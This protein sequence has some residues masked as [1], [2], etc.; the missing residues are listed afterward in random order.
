MVI[1]MLSMAGKQNAT[2]NVSVLA[3]PFPRTE[4]KFGNTDTS[5]TVGGIT[6]TRIETG[7]FNATYPSRWAFTGIEGIDTT[8]FNNGGGVLAS[9]VASSLG[10][11]FGVDVTVGMY[12]VSLPALSYGPESP[13]DWKFQGSNDNTTWTDLDTHTNIVTSDNA[14]INRVI[15]SPQSFR[16]YR[17]NVASTNGP[18]RWFIDGLWFYAPTTL[19]FSTTTADLGGH[20]LSGGNTIASKA[21]FGFDEAW[22]SSSFAKTSG[23]WWVR[24]QR[25][26]TTAPDNSSHYA[27]IGVGNANATP[28][29]FL[30]STG[31]WLNSGGSSDGVSGI[32]AWTG[33]GDVIDMVYDISGN[34][35]AVR[36]NN[37]TWGSDKA[38]TFSGSILPFVICRP[39]SGSMSFAVIPTPAS[40]IV[41]N[42]KT[43]NSLA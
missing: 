41:V 40:S 23:Q 12:R 2:S 6:Y 28:L 3:L 35:V 25:F 20:T 5:I 17:L 33:N 37:G 4:A 1:P 10:I 22:L 11:D 42:S 39:G 18:G 31:S 14:E 38:T 7:T 34:T 9:A 21:D 16:Y 8:S 30:I 19:S 29:R 26:G 15:S 27:Y 13:R 36:L 32:G 43:Y 24:F